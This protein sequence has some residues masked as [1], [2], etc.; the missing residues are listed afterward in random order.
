MYAAFSSRSTILLAVSFPFVSL[1]T[2]CYRFI[3]FFVSKLFAGSFYEFSPKNNSSF[4]LF[5]PEQQQRQQKI[6]TMVWNWWMR[7][8]EKL[9][10]GETIEINCPCR[11]T[12][13]RQSHEEIAADDENRRKDKAQTRLAERNRWWRSSRK[14]LNNFVRCSEFFFFFWG[15]P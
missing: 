10:G 8:K 12:H 13:T 6:G 7:E 3:A 4:V 9:A 14:M 2:Y 11:G 15:R 5:V 1:S